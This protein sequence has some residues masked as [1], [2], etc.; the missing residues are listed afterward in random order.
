[1]TMQ[2]Y[3]GRCA[4]I[5]AVLASLALVGTMASAPALAAGPLAGPAGGRVG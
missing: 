1:M 3:R 2:G 4:A 5:G